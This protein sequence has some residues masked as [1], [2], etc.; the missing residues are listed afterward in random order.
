MQTCIHANKYAYKLVCMHTCLH[1]W[2]A[3]N[4]DKEE[5]QKG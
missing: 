2:L 4:E 1:A 5:R 3:D